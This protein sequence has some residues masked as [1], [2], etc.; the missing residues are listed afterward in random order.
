MHILIKYY[1]FLFQVSY[2][3]HLTIIW[4]HGCVCVSLIIYCK[5]IVIIVK[6]KLFC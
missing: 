1:F 5:N 2:F 3:H 6:N 4:K